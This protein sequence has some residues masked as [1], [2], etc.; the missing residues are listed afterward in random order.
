M[1]LSLPPFT[2]AVSWLLGINTGI[3]L[4][5]AL[6]PLIR[7]G[8]VNE[9]IGYDCALTPIDV[10]HGKIWQ[11]VTYSVLHLNIWH[12]VGNMIGLW[13][14][15]S[16][17]ESAWGTRRFLEL[18]WIGVVGAAITTVALSY[19]HLLGDPNHSTIGL[20]A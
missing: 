8:I 17:F 18:Y 15:G 1:T 6:L 3:F 11:L 20:R 16:Q 9:Y 5:M 14:F 19:T 10:V 4:L 7:L 12:L 2:R 13:M